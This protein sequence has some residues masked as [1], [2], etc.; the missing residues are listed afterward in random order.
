MSN[1]AIRPEVLA[2]RYTL[3]ELDD[4]RAIASADYEKHVYRRDPDI[5][6]RK[7]AG[8]EKSEYLYN[9]IKA[10]EIKQRQAKQNPNSAVG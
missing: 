3:A 10:Q 8:E 1:K 6:G 2:S 7:I 9:I 5:E 4:M